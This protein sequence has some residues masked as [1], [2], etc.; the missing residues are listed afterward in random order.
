MAADL[1]HLAQAQAGLVG[2]GE[3]RAAEA[4]GAHSLDAYLFGQLGDGNLS[5]SD[6]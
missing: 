1:S 3:G 4:V 5:A 6:A 2:S